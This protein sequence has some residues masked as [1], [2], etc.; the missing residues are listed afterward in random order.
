MNRYIIIGWIGYFDRE[1]HKLW[2]NCKLHSVS[3]S[4]TLC[5]YF[6][7]YYT[8]ELNCEDLGI[9]NIFHML[10]HVIHWTEFLSN[11]ED[12]DPSLIPKI[13]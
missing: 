3:L 9:T 10:L 2:W 6:V 4:I 13:K 8:Y 5:N 7:C 12:L 11:T 1:F